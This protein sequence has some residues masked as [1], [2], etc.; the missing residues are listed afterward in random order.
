M[1][2]PTYFFRECPTCGR[3]LRIRVAHLGKRV[4]CLHCRGQFDAVDPAS[5]CHDLCEEDHPLLRRAE[6]LLESAAPQNRSDN[7]SGNPR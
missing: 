2:N 3:Q 6:E 4:A 5:L 7:R 1:S